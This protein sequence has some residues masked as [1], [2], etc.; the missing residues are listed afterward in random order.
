MYPGPQP[1][2]PRPGWVNAKWKGWRAPG[3]AVGGV[4]GDYG[5]LHHK[6]AWGQRGEDLG[7]LQA[8]GE[9]QPQEF[10]SLQHL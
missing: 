10:V 1:L 7:L 4:S 2:W 8:D 5:F 6:P 9:W 3:K